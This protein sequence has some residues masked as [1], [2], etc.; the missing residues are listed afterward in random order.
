[1]VTM[2]DG[3]F[4]L[5]R[6]HVHLGLGARATPLPDFT[7]SPEYLADYRTRYE[8]DGEE[9]R[10][11]CVLPQDETW[12]SWERHPA[13]EELV[14]LISGRVD[15]VQELDGREHVVE[16]RPGDAVINPPNVWHTARVH[17][18]GQALFITPGWGTEGRPGS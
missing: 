10:L 16:L 8:A 2:T 11:V 18:P 6:T 1:M 17:E 14:F 7:W 3:P 12:D 4:E 13:G 9:G 15:I 5:S